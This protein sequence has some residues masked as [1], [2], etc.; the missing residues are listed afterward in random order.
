MKYVVIVNGKPGS[1]KT[2]FERKCKAYL[3]TNEM[4]WCYIHSSIAPIKEIYKQLG[5]DGKKT[6]EARRNLSIL[7]QMWIDTNNGPLKHLIDYVYKLSNDEDHIIFTDIREESEI[8]KAVEVLSVLHYIGIKCTTVFVD[9]ND[10]DIN[11]TEYGNKSDDNVGQNMSIYDHIIHNDG[12]LDSLTET[13]EDFI[14]AI[15]PVMG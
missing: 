5:W 10:D 1:G 2:T 4:A 14:D 3:N 6:D 9:R 15:L 13:A 7:K 8:V 11:G 12:D